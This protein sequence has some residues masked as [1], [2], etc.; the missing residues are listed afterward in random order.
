[1]ILQVGRPYA[2]ADADRARKHRQR[3]KQ[4][5]MHLAFDADEDVIDALIRAG[6]LLATSADNSSAVREAA[7]KALAEWKASVSRPR[8]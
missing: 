1:M 2:M 7:S 3:R 8:K 5:K 6:F 4:G